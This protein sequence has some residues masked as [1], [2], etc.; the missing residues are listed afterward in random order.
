MPP[1]LPGDGPARRAGSARS[2]CPERGFPAVLPAQPADIVGMHLD[3]GV[4]AGDHIES[5]GYKSMPAG[6]ASAEATDAARQ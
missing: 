1:A 6:Y 4:R 2:Q 5:A 3:A